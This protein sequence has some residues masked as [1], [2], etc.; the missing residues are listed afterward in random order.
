MALNVL[1]GYLNKF[2]CW[3]LN[4]VKCIL[5]QVASKENGVDIRLTCRLVAV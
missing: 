4:L 1:V 2:S 3:F 5:R